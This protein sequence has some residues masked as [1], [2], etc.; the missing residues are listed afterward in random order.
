MKSNRGFKKGDLVYANILRWE[1]YIHEKKYIKYT[2]NDIR[3]A[4]IYTEYILQDESGEHYCLYDDQ[5]IDVV[6]AY[7]YELKMGFK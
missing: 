6:P 2:I 3:D 7:L 4:G 1:N 5:L